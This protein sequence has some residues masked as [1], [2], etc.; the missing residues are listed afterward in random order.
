MRRV[1]WNVSA[2][3][4]ALAA[5]AYFFDGCGL[6]SALA[7]AALAHELGHVLALR[8]CAC[9]IT[10]CSIT[11][12]GVELDYAPRLE[13]LRCALC[14][15]AGPLAGALYA[16]AAFALSGTFWKMSGALSVLLSVFNM[17]P[18]LPL[19]GGRIA[20]ALLPERAARFVSGAMALCLLAGGAAL[21]FY[22]SVWGLLCMASW[23]FLCNLRL[24][25]AAG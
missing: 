14:L 1:R 18:I 7:P 11:L 20:A 13:G 3:A 4:I 2:G 23:L 9:R 17:L 15:L 5:L 12:T 16:A 6:V 8:L 22:A 25:S 21:A 24:L 19:D 10:R